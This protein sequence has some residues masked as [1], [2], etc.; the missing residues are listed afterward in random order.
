MGFNDY[1]ALLQNK[2]NK[3]L[4]TKGEF[5]KEIGVSEAT[6]DR[7]RKQGVIRSG[8]VGGQIFFTLATV[9]EYIAA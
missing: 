5:A 6:I 4:L 9:A 7:L 1:V 2:Y 3:M 8:K